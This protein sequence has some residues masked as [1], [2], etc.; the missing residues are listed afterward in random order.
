MFKIPTPSGW[1]VV[2]TDPKHIDE[3][4]K[5]PDNKLCQRKPVE[6]ASASRFLNKLE[7]ESACRRLCKHN[8]LSINDWKKIHFMSHWSKQNLRDH[9]HNCFPMFT[10][11]SSK[12]AMNF[13]LSKIAR[14]VLYFLI[15]WGLT[16]F[17]RMDERQ[18]VWRHDENCRSSLQQNICWTYIMWI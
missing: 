2:V 17:C 13:F 5:A 4:R 3:I 16:V 11:R 6:Q 1:W 9:Y 10:T 7:S 14:I 18:G 8:S 15:F 12:L